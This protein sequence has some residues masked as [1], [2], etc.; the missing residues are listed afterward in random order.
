MSVIL[1]G[2]I[3]AVLILVALMIAYVLVAIRWPSWSLVLIPISVA[4][5]RTLP[6]LMGIGG[7]ELALAVLLLILF[8]RLVVYNVPIMA[9]RFLILSIALL[10]SPLLSMAVKN[11]ELDSVRA[12]TFLGN[13]LCYFLTRNLVTQRSHVLP[14]LLMY[15]AI[16]NLMLLAD[17]LFIS[18]VPLPDSDYAWA[19]YRSEASTV[20]QAN[21]V[22]SLATMLLPIGFAALVLMRNLW[23]RLLGAGIIL[24]NA[25]L[26]T[27]VSTRAFFYQ[28][29]IA[30]LAM[31]L[32]MQKG[33]RGKAIIGGA[34]CAA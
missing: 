11:G 30:V 29:A 33:R 14:L 20:G 4:L 2:G 5:P 6:R 18:G 34:V 9:D 13:S 22:V 8:S 19:L 27:L 15:A 23:L 17:F 32:L 1:Q 26:A 16:I 7:M 3:F 31:T 21:Y 24:I 12:Y 25:V 10:V 28:T